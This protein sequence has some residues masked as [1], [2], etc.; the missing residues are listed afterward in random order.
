MY[1]LL[2]MIRQLAARHAL[3]HALAPIHVV[4]VIPVAL[5]QYKSILY[6]LKS[7]V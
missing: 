7:I 6:F 1:I 3:Q 2:S 5:L 4:V